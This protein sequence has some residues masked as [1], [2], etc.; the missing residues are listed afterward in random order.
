MTTL[1]GAPERFEGGLHEIAPGV[2]AWL[3]PNGSWGETNA[4]LIAG[5]G[6]SLLVDTLWTPELTRRMLEAMSAVTEAA[7]IRYVVNTHADGDHCWGNKVL[8][9]VET[10]ATEAAAREMLE[11]PPRTLGAFRAL[12]TVLRA[13]TRLR[14]PGSAA[15]AYVTGMLAPFDFG[16][17]EL[18]PPKHTF[19]GE[20][21][22]DVGGRRVE[23]I[24]VGP[25]H[26]GGDLIVHVPDAS[27]VIAADIL[28]AGVAPV[29]WA[30]PVERWLAALDRIAALEPEVVLPGHGPTSTLADVG[31]MRDYWTFVEEQADIRFGE[32]LSPYD[33]AREI[34]AGEAFQAAPWAQWDHPERIAIGINTIYRR[35]AGGRGKLTPPARIRIFDEVGRLA[36]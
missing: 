4:A 1:H 5:N 22:L 34:L 17:V 24:E 30:G 2:H 12:A 33:A 23:L 18:A 28:F 36:R 9:G 35:L 14:L 20:L 21:E 11:L 6:E 25:A 10:I 3:A 31:L 19:A 8:S 7:P 29:M 16:E 13:G 15:G 32:G 26:T 27:A